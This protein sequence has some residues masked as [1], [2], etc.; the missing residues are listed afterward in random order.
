MAKEI[1]EE[2]RSAIGD[3]DA[4]DETYTD[5]QLNIFIR[6]ALKRLKVRAGIDIAI[7]N[8]VL[9]PVPTTEES[10]LIGLQ[11]Q[12]MIA[13]RQ[14][15]SATLKGVKVKQDDSSVDTSAGLSGLRE[16]VSGDGSPCAQLEDLLREYLAKVAGAVETYGDAVWSGNSR[17]YEDVDHDGQHSERIFRPGPGGHRKRDSEGNYWWDGRWTSEGL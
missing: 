3:D 17:L 2:I 10:A 11:T 8:G 16:S 15:R 6:A 13:H 1:R 14:F 9:A 4:S 5:H 12:C 7:A